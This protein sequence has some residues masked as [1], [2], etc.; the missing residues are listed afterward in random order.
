MGWSFEEEVVTASN[1]PSGG[2]MRI[3]SMPLEKSFSYLLI[4]SSSRASG[5]QN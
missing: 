3:E 4:S 1:G 5:N 2:Q